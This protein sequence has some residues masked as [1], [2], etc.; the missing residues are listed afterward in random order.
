[1][2]IIRTFSLVLSVI[3]GLLG[4]VAF[5]TSPSHAQNTIRLSFANGGWFIGGSAGSGTLYFK[6][7]SY[8]LSVGGLTAGLVFGGAV[9]EMAGTVSNIHRPGDINGIYS[10]LSAGVAVAG[11]VRAMELR[12][13]N[14][15]VLRLRGRQIGL[16]LNLDLSGMSIALR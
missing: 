6:G 5:S 11:G 15:V 4:T 14:G 1:M 12:N 10:A 8:P 3:L 13:A 9:T 16:Q 7:H 2:K